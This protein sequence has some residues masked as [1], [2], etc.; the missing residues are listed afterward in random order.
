MEIEKLENE[1]PVVKAISCPA[2]FA[3]N[4]DFAQFCEQC[5]LKFGAN[6]N[7]MDIVHSEAELF[8]KATATKPKFI[9]LFG[10]WV[11]FLPM[12]ALGLGL[13]LSQILYESG[14]NGFL[15]FWLGII[16]FSIG[17]FFLYNVIH[18]YFTMKEKSFNQKDELV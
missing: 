6:L 2:C 12:V 7:P 9:V 5:N 14:T 11:I 10:V 18:N 4:D 3:I 15:F 17:L 1:N 16:S 8:R 13:S